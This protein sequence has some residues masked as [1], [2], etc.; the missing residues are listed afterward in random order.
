MDTPTNRPG[1]SVRALWAFVVSPI[2]AG[3]I[4]LGYA[5]AF[6]SDVPR[7]PGAAVPDSAAL[8]LLFLLSFVIYFFVIFSPVLGFILLLCA[9]IPNPR[10]SSRWLWIIS[11]GVFLLSLPAFYY[12]LREIRGS[13][14]MKKYFPFYHFS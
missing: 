11:C 10:P 6:V 13:P 4:A 5:I 8:P 1:K 14:P 12:C 7:S 2:L 3:I 9:V